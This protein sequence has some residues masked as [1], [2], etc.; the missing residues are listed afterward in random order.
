[1]RPCLFFIIFELTKIGGFDPINNLPRAAVLVV[2]GVL[3]AP[4][5][6]FG[7]PPLV[8]LAPAVLASLVQLVTRTIGLF[9]VP[10]MML[11]GLMKAMICPFCSMLALGLVCTDTW[12]AGE[13]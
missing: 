5:T 9:A 8:V 2:P 10:A 7:V 3:F 11:Y 1:M 6:G 12:S 13:E 4:L